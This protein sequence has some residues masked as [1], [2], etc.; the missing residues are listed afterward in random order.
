MGTMGY[1]YGSEWHLLRWMGRHQDHF[2]KRVAQSL[3]NDMALPD[4]HDLIFRWLDQDFDPEALFLDAEWEALDFLDPNNAAAQAWCDFWPQRG[5]P[6]NWDAV[7]EVRINGENEWLLVEAKANVE[8]LR[9]NCGAKERGGRPLIR[10]RLHET[11]CYILGRS[12]GP[13]FAPSEEDIEA[14]LRGYYQY[15]NRL[16]VL[17]F[18]R[19]HGVKARLLFIYFYGDQHPVATCP[20]IE[21]DWS[22]PLE[23]MRN[24]L[25]IDEARNTLKPFI[26][27]LYLPVC[28]KGGTHELTLN[29]WHSP[30]TP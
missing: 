16:A 17:H 6:P 2:D 29:N 30:R 5:T 21:Q 24:H 23:A 15:A 1:G 4:G 14:W 20:P 13:D 22:V 10:K 11:R 19:K 18:L 27:K 9:S 28:P 12:V 7:G 26:H 3:R 25:G 8:E